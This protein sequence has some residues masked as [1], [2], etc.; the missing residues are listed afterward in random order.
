MENSDVAKIEID[1]LGKIIGVLTAA[2]FCLSVIF[3]WGNLEALGL[4]FSDVPTTIADHVRDALLWVPGTLSAALGYTLLELMSRRIERGLTEDELI[5]QSKKPNRTAWFRRSP[6]KLFVVLAITVIF[7][8]YLFGDVFA[9]G[10]SMAAPFM[11]YEVIRWSFAHK[12]VADS[13]SP[14]L[15]RTITFIVPLTFFMYFQGYAKGIDQLI[16][17]PTVL[18]TL[19]APSQSAEVTLLRQMEKGVLV[20]DPT[21]KAIFYRWEVVKTLSEPVTSPIKRNRVCRW[22]NAFCTLNP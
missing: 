10:M 18:L 8:N 19:S 16:E 12:G 6:Y 2:T 17:Q 14:L 9:R 5:N 4:S 3:D 7:L 20:K 13:V 1:D 11:M 15:R 22:F 21:G